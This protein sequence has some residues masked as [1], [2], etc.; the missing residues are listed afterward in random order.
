MKAKPTPKPD[1]KPATKPVLKDLNVKKEVKGG[2]GPKSSPSAP[3][4]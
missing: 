4:A 3:V 2:T 1:E